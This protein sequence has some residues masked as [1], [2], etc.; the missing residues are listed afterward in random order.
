MFDRR[1]VRGS[2]YVARLLPAD[3]GVLGIGARDKTAAA[4]AVEAA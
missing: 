4:A 3:T 2:T 1:V